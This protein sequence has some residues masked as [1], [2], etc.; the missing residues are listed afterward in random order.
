MDCLRTMCN[1]SAI[2]A[3]AFLRFYSIFDNS[4]VSVTLKKSRSKNRPMFFQRRLAFTLIE[5]LVV[6][7]I[8]AHLM[9]FLLP[10]IQQARRTQCVNNMR[11]IGQAMYNY[12]DAYVRFPLPGLF[13][14]LTSNSSIGGTLTSNTFGRFPFCPI[15][16]RRTCSIFITLISPVKNRS[17][18]KRGRPH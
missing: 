3:K 17:I 2:D 16:T 12:H 18:N 8:V 11:T 5:L 14:F 4:L 9:A 6:I 7:V 15:W 1:H 13:S 10:A